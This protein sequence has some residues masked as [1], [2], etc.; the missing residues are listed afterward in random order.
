MENDFSSLSEAERRARAINLQFSKR[1]PLR[2]RLGLREGGGFLEGGLVLAVGCVV[3]RL[4]RKGQ[5][6]RERKAVLRT[7]LSLM[8]QTGY[9]GKKQGVDLG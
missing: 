3:C 8:L 4:G 7:K 1:P 6:E 9:S 5:E 2:P